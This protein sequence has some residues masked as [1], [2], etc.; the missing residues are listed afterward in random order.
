MWATSKHTT[1]GNN[2]RRGFTIVE[3]LIVIV[4]IGILA[5]ITIVAYNGVQ[6]RASDSVVES[7]IA[8][9]M[10]K[11]ELAR[12][13][14]D[15]YP[16][17]A[18]EMPSGFRFSK[19]AYDVSL[20]N[21]YYCLDKANQQYALGVRSASM[22]GYIATNGTVDKDVTVNGAATCQ[23]IGYAWGAAGVY[24]LQGYVSSTKVWTTTW[25]WTN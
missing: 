25:G 20:N 2:D 8:A 11:L 17:T 23:R 5:A 15:R 14:L 22:R 13:E 10:K 7:D 1:I 9:A 12:V 6:K 3:L 4:V 19:S 16:E 24:S 18:A 21:I